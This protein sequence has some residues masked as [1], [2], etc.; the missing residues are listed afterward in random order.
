MELSLVTKA[1]W[2]ARV[3]RLEGSSGSGKVDR[4]RPSRNVGVTRGVHRDA[5]AVIVTA[6]P[7]ISGVEE[8]G[9]GGIE[10]GHEGIDSAPLLVVWKAPG[11][12]GKSLEFVYPVT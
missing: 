2:R 9:A 1:S 11:V 7:E 5:V 3:G 6:A 8:A 10:L 4:I 12:V